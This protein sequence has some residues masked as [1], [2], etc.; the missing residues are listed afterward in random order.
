LILKIKYTVLKRKTAGQEFV[1][2]AVALALL[3]QTKLCAE[4]V[5]IWFF[6]LLTYKAKFII[7][8]RVQIFSSVAI[9][10]SV[11]AQRLS[12]I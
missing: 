9:G 10:A 6:L 1:H 4:S 8:M 12:I 5:W 2:S 3:I 7:T 11:L